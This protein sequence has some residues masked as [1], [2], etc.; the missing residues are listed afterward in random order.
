MK[1]LLLIVL[2]LGLCIFPSYG[3]DDAIQDIILVQLEDGTYERRSIED[4]VHTD[5]LRMESIG[6]E[7]DQ[8]IENATLT[9]GIRSAFKVYPIYEESSSLTDAWRFEYSNIAE[10]INDVNAVL[11]NTEV[12]VAVFDSGLNEDIIIDNDHIDSGTRDINVEN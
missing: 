4:F 10:I 8:A 2:L 1:R 5:M 11:I 6:S 7:L 9:D 3:E 12:R